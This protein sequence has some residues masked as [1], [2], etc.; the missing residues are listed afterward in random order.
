MQNVNSREST[1]TIKEV[2]DI[3]GALGDWRGTDKTG[4]HLVDTPNGTLE[5]PIL[6]TMIR[7]SEV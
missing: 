1:K 7:T 2:Q 5:L 3:I 6:S 4:F